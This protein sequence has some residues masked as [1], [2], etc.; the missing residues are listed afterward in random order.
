MKKKR[1]RLAMLHRLRNQQ[2]PSQTRSQKTQRT[3]LLLSCK[4]SYVISTL[5]CVRRTK[6]SKSLRKKHKPTTVRK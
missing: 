5:S 2:S 1:K 3:I 4:M 6:L